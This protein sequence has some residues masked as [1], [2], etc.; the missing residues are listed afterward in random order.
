MLLHVG[1]RHLVALSCLVASLFVS[2][3]ILFANELS[4]ARSIEVV[5]VSG[6]K[7]PALLGKEYQNYSV[8]VVDGET[9]LPIPYQFDERNEGGFIY[10]S[11]GSLAIL[12]TENILDKEDELA[13]MLKD[14][15]IKAEPEQLSAVSGAVV[16]E[17]EVELGDHMRYA[18]LIEGNSER[19]EKHYTHFNKETGLI[20]TSAYTL[21]VDPDNLLVWGDYTY[22]GYAE[23][24]VSLLDTM[25]LRVNGR[26]G[27]IKATIYN[28]LIPSEIVAV[29]NGPVRSIIEMDAS[30][31]MLGINVLTVGAS[32]TITEN[33]TEFPVFLTIPKAAAVLSSL[34][35]EVS[36]DLDNMEKARYRTEL[37]PKEPVIQGGG[38]AD[39]KDLAVDLD[40]NWLSVSS[41]KNWD[42]IAF[43]NR[44]KDVTVTLEALY[45]D[46]ALDGK[47][48]KPERVK[49][50][51]PQAGYLITDI[52]TGVASTIGINLYYNKDFW[53]GNNVEIAANEIRNPANINVNIF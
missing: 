42:I 30:I 8:M 47:V 3:S 28:K 36:L 2:P 19:S 49:G 48:D 11:G 31:G 33:S 12:G 52:P 1:R 38:G 20:T 5:V 10:A 23:K 7:L 40:H 37:G 43:F 53:Q 18:Y 4:P 27:F 51:S 6:E 29:K 16:A 45:K 50:S 9:L 35:I 46:S 22:E 15:G 21:Q 26:I 25:K 34:D 39:P 14:T 44:N 24:N 32:V 41:N 13:F 17:F